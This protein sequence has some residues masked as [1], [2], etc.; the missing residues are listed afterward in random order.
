MITM[1]KTNL[2]GAIGTFSLQNLCGIK[3]KCE[4][5]HQRKALVLFMLHCFFQCADTFANQKCV[6]VHCQLSFR[7]FFI[8]VCES[9]VFGITSNNER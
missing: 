8:F 6:L 1:C 9:K 5:K 3:R 2:Q 7:I 4:N